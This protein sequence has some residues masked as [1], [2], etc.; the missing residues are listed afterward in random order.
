[1][2][3][4]AQATPEA[5]K[6]SSKRRILLIE[7]NEADAEIMKMVH[8]EVRRCSWLDIV[9][10]GP[11]ALEYLNGEGD[12]KGQKPDLILMDVSL[13]FKSGLEMIKEIRAIPGCDLIPIV[14]VSGTSSPVT[15]RQAY[16]LGANCL[17]RKSS[18]WEEYCRK[19]ESCYEFWCGVAELPHENG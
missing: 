11:H 17:I 6:P 10:H 15:L 16:Q 5:Q 14:M 8:D 1:M 3:S 7:D 12:G 4:L 18:N 19:L 13:P 2:S 9:Q